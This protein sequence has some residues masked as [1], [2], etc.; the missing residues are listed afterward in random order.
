M[1]IGEGVWQVKGWENDCVVYFD[2]QGGMAPADSVCL[3]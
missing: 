1:S 3:F 2:I